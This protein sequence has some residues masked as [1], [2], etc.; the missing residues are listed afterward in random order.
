[1]KLYLVQ[2]GRALPEE[3]DPQ[4]SLSREGK[5]QTQKTAQFLKERSIKADS[6]WHSKKTRSIQTAQIISQSVACTKMTERDDLNPKDPVDKFQGEIEK[7]NADLMIVG[8][9]PFLQKL[10]S[11]LLAGSDSLELVSFK[12]SGIVCLEYKD[13]WKL[14]WFVPPELSYF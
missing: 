8:H 4:K 5:N 14:T 2:H 13:T 6:I 7:L 9:L 3:K 11:L 1:M 10:T 12:N